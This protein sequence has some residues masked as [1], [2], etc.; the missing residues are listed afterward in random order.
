MKGCPLSL[1][2]IAPARPCPPYTTRGTFSPSARR[3]LTRWPSWLN[4]LTGL[5]ARPTEQPHPAGDV[6]RHATSPSYALLCKK[7]IFFSQFGSQSH[8][9]PIIPVPLDS[10]HTPR[11]WRPQSAIRL[12]RPAPC[13]PRSLPQPA[14]PPRLCPVVVLRRRTLTPGELVLRGD[15]P[16]HQF[17]LDEFGA[18]AVGV[19]GVMLWTDRRTEPGQERRRCNR[20]VQV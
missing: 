3:R 4:S 20:L 14:A 12:L 8:V 1:A 15:R 10:P 5:P 16:F 19:F 18:E 17:W 6:A 11:P 7:I 9:T 13:E 2:G